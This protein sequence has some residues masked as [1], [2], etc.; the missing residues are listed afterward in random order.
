[1]SI[2]FPFTYERDAVGAV[3][4]VFGVKRMSSAAGRMAAMAAV[5]D[6]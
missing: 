3:R 1:L 5:A 6:M 2:V 4:A